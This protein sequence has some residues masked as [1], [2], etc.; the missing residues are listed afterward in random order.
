MNYSHWHG[1][2]AVPAPNTC[3]YIGRDPSS[4]WAA[5]DN[6]TQPFAFICEFGE[7]ASVVGSTSF[8]LSLSLCLSV[9]VSLSPCL[10]VYPCVSLLLFQCLSVS[11]CVCLSVPLNAYLSLSDALFLFLSLCVSVSISIS[12][13]LFLSKCSPVSVYV[14]LCL[15]VS[16]SVSPA[17][18]LAL[19]VHLLVLLV[20]LGLSSSHTWIYG[21]MLSPIYTPFPVLT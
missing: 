19:P 10:S 21:E 15:F 17:H 4:R 16:H 7:L 20:S 6:C 3:G 13:S 14:M 11:L 18:I 12:V 8:D 5:S 1:G 2:Q 9:L